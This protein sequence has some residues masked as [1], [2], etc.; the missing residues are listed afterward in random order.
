[1]TALRGHPGAGTLGSCS[2]QR[3]VRTRQRVPQV[4]QTHL[5]KSLPSWISVF[6]IIVVGDSIEEVAEFLCRSGTLHPPRIRKT[7]MPDPLAE[8]RY[9]LALANRIIAHEGV[10]DGFGHVSVRH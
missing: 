5:S 7:P 2:F 1:M 3:A 10:L 4:P 9:E 6:S 8:A